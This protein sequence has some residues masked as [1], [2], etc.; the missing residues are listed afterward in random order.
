M[1]AYGGRDDPQCTACHQSKEMCFFFLSLLPLT[2]R[3]CLNSTSVCRIFARR[4]VR[5]EELRFRP[6]TSVRYV[7]T[8]QRRTKHKQLRGRVTSRISFLIQH[9]CF[10]AFHLIK[11]NVFTS[12][13]RTNFLAYLETSISFVSIQHLVFVL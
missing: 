12:S 3:F 2:R 1:R 13:E 7:F 5:S 6:L 8:P 10:T 11:Q 9:I 4:S